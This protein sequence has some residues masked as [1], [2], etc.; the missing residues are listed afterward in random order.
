M[1]PLSRNCLMRLPRLSRLP[2]ALEITLA[3]VLK[4][5]ILSLLWNAFFSSPQ[6]TKMALPPAKV[7]QHLLSARNPPDSRSVPSTQEAAHD[8]RR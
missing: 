4:L 8:T 2:F 6:T 5:A 3:L 1:R 7:E